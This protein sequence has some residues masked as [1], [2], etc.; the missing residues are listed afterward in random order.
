MTRRR[1]LRKIET[2]KVKNQLGLHAR[3]ATEVVRLLQQFKSEVLFT[4]RKETVNARSIMNL[5]MLAAPENSQIIVTAD[6]VD[7]QEAV[8]ALVDL[9]DSCFGEVTA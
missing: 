9:F 6:G 2:L 4:Y 7:A 5:L 3:P 1:A 8:Q